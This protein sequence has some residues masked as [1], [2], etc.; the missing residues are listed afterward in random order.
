MDPNIEIAAYH[1]AGHALLAY[2]VGWS[3]PQIVLQIENGALEGATTSYHN[4]QDGGYVDVINKFPSTYQVLKTM[5]PEQKDEA[6]H[7]SKKMHYCVI[8][9]PITQFYFENGR[10]NTFLFALDPDQPDLKKINNIENCQRLL[11]FFNPEQFDKEKREV[12]RVILDN[13]NTIELL[14]KTLLTSETSQLDNKEIEAVFKS[15]GVSKH[16]IMPF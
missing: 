5:T 10:S 16:F 11:G 9:G 12:A 1:E 15:T 4:Y 6:Y 13:W 2:T 7:A 14:A 3:V 8:A